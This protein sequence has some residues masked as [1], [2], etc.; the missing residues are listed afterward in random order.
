MFCGATETAILSAT[1]AL[2]RLSAHG[3]LLK[4]I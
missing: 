2:E 3:L 1:I 4:T